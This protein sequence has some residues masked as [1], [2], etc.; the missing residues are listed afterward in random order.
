MIHWRHNNVENLAMC[1]SSSFKHM[2]LS[3]NF[4]PRYDIDSIGAW[5]EEVLEVC[6]GCCPPA[7]PHRLTTRT[8]RSGGVRVNDRVQLCCKVEMMFQQHQTSV[9]WSVSNWRK[10]TASCNEP[11]STL[12]R[13]S[14]KN[15]SLPEME[16]LESHP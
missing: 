1:E 15:P 7:K 5:I 12:C 9:I 13:S 14:S 3:F 2:H 4:K 16:Q 8:Q 10:S 11:T 6:G